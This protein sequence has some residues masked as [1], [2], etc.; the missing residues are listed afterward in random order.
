M[1]IFINYIESKKININCNIVYI[2]TISFVII[3][4]FLL[5][6]F[7]TESFDGLS[8]MLEFT[9][10][11]DSL[12]RRYKVNSGYNLYDT[13]INNLFRND[14]VIRMKIPMNYGVK[15][16][17]KFKDSSKKNGFAKTLEFPEG[18]YDIKKTIGDKIIDQIII[19]NLYGLNNN[20]LVD[21]PVYRPYYNQPYRPYYNHFYRPYYKHPYRSY[22][23]PYY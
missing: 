23:R 2:V 15:V 21:Y 12:I 14:D 6:N 19:K 20:Y 9:K 5:S 4:F 8:D 11:D 17:Y 10:L 7:I 13:D 3:T 1:L 16:I 22:H 18:S